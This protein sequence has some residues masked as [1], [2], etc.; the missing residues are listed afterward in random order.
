MEDGRAAA[1]HSTGVSRA[2]LP[3]GARVVQATVR[4]K[5]TVIGAAAGH[6][7]ESDEEAL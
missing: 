1:Q 3:S 4:H 2:T 6:F 5:E 7:G